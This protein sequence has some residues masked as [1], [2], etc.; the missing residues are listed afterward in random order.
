MQ[1]PEIQEL[2]QND[3][4]F[5]RMLSYKRMEETVRIGSSLATKPLEQVDFFDILSKP[6]FIE[7]YEKMQSI[8]VIN[9][10]DIFSHS[11]L[12]LNLILLKEYLNSVSEKEY[13]YLTSIEYTIKKSQLLKQTRYVSESQKDLKELDD[14]GER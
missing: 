12:I 1:V 9:S 6:A 10:A 13:K 14:L 4:E 8:Y 7:A 3:N 5:I 11:E 2:L